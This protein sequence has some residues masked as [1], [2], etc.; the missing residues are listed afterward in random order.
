MP[1]SID[2]PPTFSNDQEYP[3]LFRRLA[4]MLYETLLLLAVIFIASWLF[5]ALTRF[6]GSGPL[7]HV[8]RIYVFVVMACYCSWFWSQGRR[9][10]AMKTWQLRL[11]EKNGQPL[12]PK[13][14]LLR[15]CL[16]WLCVT[17]IGVL[18]A[19]VDRERLFLHDRLVGTRLVISKD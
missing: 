8:F 18:W 2:L 5:Y 19:L 3:G 14:A 16:A 10:L 17:G 15:Y 13:R 12:T 4:C 1:D 11:T 9:T 7:L 6:D